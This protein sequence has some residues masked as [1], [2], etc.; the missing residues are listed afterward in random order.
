MEY[1]V[2]RMSAEP[3]KPEAFHCIPLEY[4]PI[5]R[6]LPY[7]VHVLVDARYVL[8]RNPGEVL[9]TERVKALQQRGVATLQV[10]RTDIKAYVAEVEKQLEF[11]GENRFD[12]Q[13]GLSIKSL[14]FAYVRSLEDGED[15]KSGVMKKLET[16]THRLATAIH[17]QVALAG[18]LVRRYTDPTLFFSNH[19]L[20]TCLF[21]TAIGLKHGLPSADLNEL[22]F[23]GCVANIGLMKVARETLYKPSALTTSEWKLI[24]AHPTEGAAVLSVLLVPKRVVQAV[25]EHHERFDGFGYPKG[26]KGAEISL[27]ARI[28]AIAEKFSELTSVK[29]WGPGIPADQA[30]RLM[31]ENA[32]R[33]DPA[34]LSM[35]IT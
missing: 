6:P 8:L 2:S 25:A 32:S 34:L 5:D 10:L 16:M 15:P 27:F 23:A 31:R 12:E 30:I 19:A 11:I 29:P 20:N 14:I 18:K 4:I 1:D 33:F 3:L 22:A 17:Q 24:Q 35:S 13:T 21:S 7:S 28:I 9:T 26:I